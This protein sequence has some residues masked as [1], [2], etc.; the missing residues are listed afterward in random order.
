MYL[1]IVVC[2]CLVA[3]FDERPVIFVA[4]HQVSTTV[5][6]ESKCWLLLLRLSVSSRCAENTQLNVRYVYHS[7]AIAK[8]WEAAV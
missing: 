6:F 4:D 2:I 7:G 5:Y 1:R 3:L 8:V